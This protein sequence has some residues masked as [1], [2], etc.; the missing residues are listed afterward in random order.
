MTVV[1]ILTHD[2]LQQRTVFNIHVSRRILADLD[3]N[4][5]FYKLFGYIKP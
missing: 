1:T 5:L 2:G 4:D 3:D